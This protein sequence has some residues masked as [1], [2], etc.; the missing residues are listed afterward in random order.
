[1][2]KDNIRKAVGLLCLANASFDFLEL[3]EKKNKKK[4]HWVKSWRL[5]RDSR[6][7]FKFLTDELRLEDKNAFRQ[8][9]R[10]DENC[11]QT[12]LGYVENSIRKQNTVMREAVSPEE[13]LVAVL[14]FL[15]TGETYRS[16]D[17]QT[18]LSLSFL[19]KAVPEVCEAIHNQMKGDY[20]KVKFF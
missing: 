9:L 14:R 1:M 17:F 19:S 13:T 20:L 11:F 3:Q 10:M 12:I 16:L 4:R 15:A 7:C 18:R 6:S 8:F 5:R 2:D